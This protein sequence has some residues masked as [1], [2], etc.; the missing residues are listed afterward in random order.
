MTQVLAWVLLLVPAGVFLLMGF[1]YVVRGTPI[2]R[3][4]SATRTGEAPGIAD[5]RFPATLELLTHIDFLP[6]NA[7]ELFTC[8]DETYPRMWEDLRNA[9]RSITLQMYYANPG[10]V[11]DVTQR[12]LIERARAGVKVLF[13]RDAFGAGGLPQSYFDAMTDAGVEV[14]TFR[15]I[16]W[17]S[18][19][20]AYARS[21]IRV[22]V[23]D[24]HVAYTGGFGLDDKWLGDGRS[25]DHWR[26]TTVRFTGPSVAH[27]QATFAAGWADATGQLLT[28]SL[29]FPFD[30]EQNGDGGTNTTP[31]RASVL[32]AAPTIGSTPAE[33]FLALAI[34]GATERLWIT[35]AYF[36]PD[37]D[38]AGL[39]THASERGAD[40]RVL[41]PSQLTDSTPVF[42]AG[43][44]TYG[45][46]L[47]GGVRIY[48]Y[49]PTMHHAKTFVADH[50]L[51]GVGTMNF[52]NRSMA[53]NDESVF[54]AYDR[55]F[56]ERLATIFEED[57]RYAREVTLDD[58]RR[59]PWT[60]RV[61][62]RVAYM[63][64]RVL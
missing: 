28:G 47:A 49:L 24:A 27:L 60:E 21:H 2:R 17:Y 51:A 19:E 5:E 1:R 54:V 3:I 20:R 31:M 46:L 64:R 6:G 26:D 38:F 15:P 7:A 50:D 32:H 57:L 41:V 14:A 9:Q 29:F 13:L 18:L 37:L 8:G 53:F 40:V 52:D 36:V 56:N 11:A 45:P 23:I 16:H 48:E 30:P 42:Y 59:R 22:V 10:R 34:G 35:N 39:L 58:W 62:S 25:A 63:F 43:R 44:E 33:R 61:A 4:R 12:I 55:D